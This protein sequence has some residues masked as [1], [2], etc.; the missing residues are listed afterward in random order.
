MPSAKNKS[1][2]VA[3][4]ALLVVLVAGS[5]PTLGQST[6]DQQG[7]AKLAGSNADVNKIPAKKLFGR[8]RLP[9]NLRAKAIGTYARGCL[10]GGKAV[11]I[12]GPTWQVMRLSRNRNWGHPELVSLVEDIAQKAK[13]NDGWN[14]LLIGDLSQ[15]RGGPML[16]GHASHQIGLDADI[17][18]NPMPDRILTPKERENISAT[19]VTKSRFAIDEKVWTFFVKGTDKLSE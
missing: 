16:T 12:N 15:P 4:L 19:L 6:T 3:S 2:V 14:G 17:W 5:V 7:L 1:S 18:L 9:A 10:S 8:Q 11:P 13:A